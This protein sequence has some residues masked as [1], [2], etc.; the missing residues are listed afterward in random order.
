MNLKVNDE[1]HP[2]KVA[3]VYAQESGAQQAIHLLRNEGGFSAEE[4]NLVPPDDTNFDE[5]IEPDD[6][7]IGRTLLGSHIILGGCGLAVGLILAAI[8][9]VYGPVLTTSSPTMVFIGLATLGTFFGLLVA[10]LVSLRPDHD[11]LI[12]DTRHATNNQQWTVIVQTKDDEQQK[13]AKQL[14]QGSA[15]SVSHSF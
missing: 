10:G 15:V 3:G 11:G 12:N 6:K 2:G 4:V 5:K 7:G 9:S 14:M 1:K 13:Q 8:L